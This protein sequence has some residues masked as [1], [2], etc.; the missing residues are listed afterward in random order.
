VVSI[1][2]CAATQPPERKIECSAE[3]LRVCHT[4]HSFPPKITLLTMPASDRT[5]KKKGMAR[6]MDKH[7][8]V[9]SAV[10]LLKIGSITAC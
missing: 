9:F 6:Q 4:R 5:A 10:A 2:R 7:D 1:R 3:A 8:M